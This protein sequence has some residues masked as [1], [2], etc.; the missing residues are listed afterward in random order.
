MKLLAGAYMKK[1]SIHHGEKRPSKLLLLYLWQ[2]IWNFVHIDQLICDTIEERWFF[3]NKPFHVR[4]ISSSLSSTLIPPT[5]NKESKHKLI[6]L[7][8][9]GSMKP[10]GSQPNTPVRRTICALLYII[11][12]DFITEREENYKRLMKTTNRV[13]WYTKRY[14]KY[15]NFILLKVVKCI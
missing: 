15:V 6:C 10:W 1:G 7:I 5:A 12:P 3:F 11:I 2:N 13:T 9:S 8:S 4:I 14:F